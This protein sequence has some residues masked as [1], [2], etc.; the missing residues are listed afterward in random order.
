MAEKT[1][2]SLDELTGGNKI[3]ILISDTSAYIVRE[4]SRDDFSARKLC[5]Q[6]VHRLA[7]NGKAIINFGVNKQILY[8]MFRN[9]IADIDTGKIKLTKMKTQDFGNLVLVLE[10]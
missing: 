8:T 9:F 5:V 10:A 3:D 2:S 1:W 4:L 7:P 6:I